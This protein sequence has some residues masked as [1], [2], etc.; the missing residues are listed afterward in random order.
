MWIRT[1]IAYTLLQRSSILHNVMCEAIEDFEQRGH[2]IFFCNVKKSHVKGQIKEEISVAEQRC[3]NAKVARIDSDK[4]DIIK[5]VTW[6]ILDFEL[7][8]KNTN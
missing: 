8:H 5:M 4:G 6:L 1:H 3:S 7:S 2:M